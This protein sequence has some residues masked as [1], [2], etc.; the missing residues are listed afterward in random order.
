MRRA[1]VLLLGIA[2]LGSGSGCGG[3]DGTEQAV[4]DSDAAR[5][6][7]PVA[8]PQAATETRAALDPEPHAQGRPLSRQEREVLRMLASS[9]GDA[10]GR[11]DATVNSCEVGRWASCTDVAWRNIVTDLDWPPYYLRRF[12]TQ[13]RQCGALSNAV[14]GVYG[15]TNAARQLDYSDPDMDTSFRRTSHPT[16][17][18]GLRPVPPELLDAAAGGCR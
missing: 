7:A 17:V 6:P 11:Y 9:I 18:D 12:N 1:L 16:L 4:G 14:N 3:G 13:T 15:F 8:P 10:I 2:I 5:T